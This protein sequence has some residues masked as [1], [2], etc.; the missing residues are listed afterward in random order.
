[1][2][3]A[4]RSAFQGLSPNLARAFQY[5]LRREAKPASV[6]DWREAA[7]RA[8]PE[9]IWAYV[10]DGADARV[11]RDENEAAFGDWRLRQR[12]LTGC[13]APGLSR[14]F[15]GETL[16]LPVA[17]APTGM[18]G[19]SHWSGDIACARAA[20]GAG[21]RYVVSTAASYTVEEIAAATEAAHWFQ[22]YCFGDRETV[23]GLMGRAQAA[24]YTALFLTVDTA[25]RGNRESEVRTGMTVP[26][27]LTPGA[28]W[29][30]LR[31]PRWTWAALAHRRTS[32]I[33]Y[34]ELEQARAGESELERAARVQARLMQTDLDWDDLAWMR[35][36]WPG[37]LYVKGVLDPE[38]AA[39]A[40]LDAGADGVVVSN[41]G[42]RQ[43]DQAL[44]TLR[45]LPAIRA[46]LGGRGEV[47]LD[48]G[49]RR[50]GD[51]VKALALG[52][53]GVFIG[54]AYV[55]GLAAAGERGVAEVL[56]LLRD[57][58]VRTLVL[59]GCPDVA[60]LDPSWLLPGA[61]PAP[62]NGNRPER[63]EPR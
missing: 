35:D 43:L 59:M 13:A 26:P 42:G 50:G 2:S 3:R 54:R 24:G 37:K 47:L 12:C 15:A 40:V 1:M 5:R 29:D 4:A 41:H 52:A 51:V 48:G 58:L 38:D 30:F 22:L 21:T 18:T 31:H 49:I 57:D 60:E 7:R 56:K 25:V 14:R 36:R 27:T 17:L 8:L 61:G 23:G 10:E 34:A 46:R 9:M 20:E 62:P 63:E 19:L 45:A 11:T 28:A 33:H 39:R 16:A 55:Y 53:D 32:P 44:S 6:A